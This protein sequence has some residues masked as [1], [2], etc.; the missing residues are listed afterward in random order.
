VPLD[1]I[2]LDPN[3]PRFVGPNWQE[4]DDSQIEAGSVQDGVRRTLLRDYD[5]EKL[6]MNMEINGYLPIDRIVVRQFKKDK[7]VVLEGNRRIAAAKMISKIGSDGNA[8]PEEVLASVAEIPCL[9]YVGSEQ[10]A[11]WIFQGLRHITGIIEWPA[12]NKARLLVEQMEEEGLTLT[13]AGKRFGLTAFGAGQ[14]VRGYYAFK[15]AREESDYIKE[16][17]ERAY[18]YF[19]ELFS[20][21][22][23]RVRDWMSWNDEE[24]RFM[25]GL[26]LNEF[27]GWLY[28]R[29]ASDEAD[30]GA[31]GDWERRWLSRRDDIRSIAYLLTSSEGYF[32][33]FRSGAM[34]LEGAYALATAEAY[35]H[36]SAETADRAKEVFDALSAAA[37]A[38]E[39][40][41]WKILK[42]ETLRN[43]LNDK[44][45]QIESLISAIRKP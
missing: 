8:V 15:Q 31:Q 22:S 43:T 13:D 5:V 44:L 42:D 19:Q 10:D 17:D 14:W 33:K 30:S 41:P 20:K 25:N 21:S 37:K 34:T 11:A 27:I 29:T 35:Q 9:Q 24:Y 23:S 39:D 4:I 36:K 18:P 3:N 12:Y 16:V 32:E 6:R 1:C 26:A 38:L 7:F 28:P 2:Y 40:I 45:A